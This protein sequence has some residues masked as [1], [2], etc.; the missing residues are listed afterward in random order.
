L[1]LFLNIEKNFK[2]IFFKADGTKISNKSN[3]TTST[4]KKSISSL[5]ILNTTFSSTSIK[6]PSSNSTAI[7]TTKSI[8]GYTSSF[9]TTSITTSYTTSF[10]NTTTIEI[11]YQKREA[12]KIFIFFVFFEGRIQMTFGFLVIL[13]FVLAFIFYFK[14][15]YFFKTKILYKQRKFSLNSDVTD[16]NSLDAQPVLIWFKKF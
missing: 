5:T 15:N 12:F 14:R 16:Y 8:S 6:N 13:F 9:T 4:T 11:K 2:N 7:A 3:S 10:K 1:I